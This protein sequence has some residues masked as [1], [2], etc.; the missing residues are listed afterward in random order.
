M[1]VGG[2]TMDLSCDDPRHKER[3]EEWTAS[4][5]AVYLR[6]LDGTSVPYSN[7]FSGRNK[8]ACKLQAIQRGWLLRPTGTCVCWACQQVKKSMSLATERAQQEERALLAAWNASQP[9]RFADPDP[10]TPCDGDGT[11]EQRTLFAEE[12]SHATT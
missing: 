9:L 5:G 10:S 4:T 3:F 11:D 6:R 8:Q 12:P 7:T 2:Y 1:I